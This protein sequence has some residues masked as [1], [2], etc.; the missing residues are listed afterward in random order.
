MSQDVLLAA[1]QLAK[2]FLRILLQDLRHEIRHLRALRVRQRV[3]LLL[4]HGLEQR[5]LVHALVKEWI[6]PRHH[7]VYQH[8]QGP[9]VRPRGVAAIHHD[10]RRQVVR[11]A[12]ERVRQLILRHMLRKSKVDD[13]RITLRVD[14][15]I[16]RL[17]IAKDE[18]LPVHVGQGV[19]DIQ[20]VE[21]GLILIHARV[22]F[23]V[24]ILAVD[25]IPQ[26][27]STHQ[28]REHVDVQVVLVRIDEIDD[29]GV[30]HLLDDRDFTLDR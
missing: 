30:V 16:L 19:R 8:A 15:D 14:Q 28:A 26:L 29:V 27:A 1:P 7:L 23:S 22:P 18:V 17:Q 4:H 12:A 5:H 20:G 10:L 9:M 21:L 13:R 3:E 2:A 6:L 11:G 24:F 25:D